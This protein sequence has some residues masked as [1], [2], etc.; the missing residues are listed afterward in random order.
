MYPLAPSSTHY[1][2][3]EVPRE[4]TLRAA[5]PG[6]VLVG[7]SVTGHE[8]AVG[9]VRLLHC[10]LGPLLHGTGEVVLVLDETLRAEK[11]NT[12]VV[13]VSSPPANLFVVFCKLGCV[14]FG[15]EG[16]SGRGKGGAVHAIDA[17]EVMGGGGEG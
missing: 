13:A 2:E 5:H 3:G 10:V 6:L 14:F 16:G 8:E 9:H 17:S 4:T 1:R 11:L 7:F 12:L 15:G